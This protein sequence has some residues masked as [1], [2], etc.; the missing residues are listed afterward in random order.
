VGG[1][2]G[3]KKKKKR[4]LQGRTFPHK[5]TLRSVTTGRGKKEGKRAKATSS[6]ESWGVRREQETVLFK[7]P[8]GSCLSRTK[9]H[10]QGGRKKKGIKKEGE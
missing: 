8:F 7:L 1:G 3:E 4:N 6:K 2:G 5:M 10:P 9:I